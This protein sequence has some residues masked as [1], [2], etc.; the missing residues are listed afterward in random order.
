MSPYLLL[1]KFGG[2]VVFF[3]MIHVMGL[4]FGKDVGSARQVLV[5][6]AVPFVNLLYGKGDGKG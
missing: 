1:R 5:Q 6:P 4:V 3:P 2:K